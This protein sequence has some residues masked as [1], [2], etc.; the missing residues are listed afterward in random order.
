MENVE[1]IYKKWRKKK[2][3]MG[4]FSFKIYLVICNTFFK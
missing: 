4:T 1:E 3:E 2:F